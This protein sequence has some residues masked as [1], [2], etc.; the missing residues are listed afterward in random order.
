MGACQ[1]VHDYLP[2]IDVVVFCARFARTPHGAVPPCL[3]WKPRSLVIS[4]IG[5][6]RSVLLG[7]LI[8]AAVLPKH[9]PMMVGSLRDR[10]YLT[11]LSTTRDPAM[12]LMSRAEPFCE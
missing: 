10:N 4:Y 8:N 7:R 1:R 2:C 12:S 3:S 11:T 9:S 6:T 5:L